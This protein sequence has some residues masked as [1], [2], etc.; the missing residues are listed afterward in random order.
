MRFKIDRIIR[1]HLLLV[2]FSRIKKKL[3]VFDY[4][5]LYVYITQIYFYVSTFHSW[6]FNTYTL[7]K[8]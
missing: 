7:D 1:Y 6:C 8:Y 4:T 5:Q 2:F 3:N